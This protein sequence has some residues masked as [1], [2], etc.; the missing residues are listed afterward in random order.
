MLVMQMPA[1]SAINGSNTG[2]A[3]PKFCERAFLQDSLRI[4]CP[5]QHIPRL[6]SSNTTGRRSHHYSSRRQVLCFRLQQAFIAILDTFG[7]N[8]EVDTPGLGGFGDQSH[9]ADGATILDIDA[10]HYD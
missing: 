7:R 10:R 8:A 6:F 4:K 2:E 1:W 9:S 3:S 5:P